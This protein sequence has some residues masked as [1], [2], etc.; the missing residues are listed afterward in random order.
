MMSDV[1]NEN[2][3]LRELL[4]TVLGS[5]WNLE[6]ESWVGSPRQSELGPLHLVQGDSGGV[7]SLHAVSESALMPKDSEAK[8]DNFHSR[9]VWCMRGTR[10]HRRVSF[11]ETG[12]RINDF[13]GSLQRVGF[14]RGSGYMG[15][16]WECGV[17]LPTS[18][19]RLIWDLVSAFLVF[20]DIIMVP[21]GFFLT[22][23]IMG[24]IIMD[25]ATL[26]FWTFDMGASLC[27]GY[28]Q[29]GVLILDPKAIF[30]QYCK[31]CMPLDILIQGP[32]WFITI[33]K[34]TSAGTGDDHTLRGPRLA[35]VFRI[36]RVLRLLRVA[37]ISR[38]LR[39]FQDRI[40]NELWFIAIEVFTM[41]V[42]IAWLIHFLGALWYF[43]GEAAR[44]DDT[45][46]WT[47]QDYLYEQ[48]FLERYI[49]SVHWSWGFF[50]FGST[51]T[52]PRNTGERLLAILV[53]V[54]GMCAFYVLICL[55]MDWIL[56]I[57]EFRGASSKQMWLLR[58][59]FRQKRVGLQLSQR[60][61]RFV[62][63]K[64][65]E[66]RKNVSE[67]SVHIL[68][69]L[70]KPLRRELDYVTT[71]AGVHAH[72]LF[73]YAEGLSGTLMHSLA[74]DVLTTSQFAMEDELFH[75]GSM[76]PHMFVCNA[77]DLKY[78]HRMTGN[79]TLILSGNWLCEP[80]LWVAWSCRGSLLA[81]TDCQMILVDAVR[82]GHWAKQ[83]ESM[84]ALMSSYAEVFLE[85]LNA[86]DG[87]LIG[88]QTMGDTCRDHIKEAS[89]R[90]KDLSAED[91]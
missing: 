64:I 47:E 44:L 90:M 83:D 6:G 70:S 73:E 69:I 8:H 24:L 51:V 29:E 22:D 53:M 39:K 50:A 36:V 63:E 15:T 7:L 59:F 84:F 72:P 57:R 11:A 82:F 74:V 37:K 52:Q 49:T 75:R 81:A 3:Q 87:I 77:G 31:T 26:I 18:T 20:Y 1:Q 88:D 62:E 38:L 65:E 48:P 61:Q 30:L 68:N 34:L 43:V 32:Q 67:K 71:F 27:T 33:A 13:R 10:S 55:C 54:I 78:V 21:I 85:W 89:D 60:I 35:R 58:R 16:R 46:S 23:D 4:D 86:Q 25:W 45:A 42:V 76:V 14:D 80:V 19:S 12:R 2:D 40:E 28:T 41:L 56:R 5:T 17:V 66:D 79:E 9:N 91:E